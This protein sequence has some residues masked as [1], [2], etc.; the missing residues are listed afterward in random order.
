MLAI[1]PILL[2]DPQTK[3]IQKWLGTEGA[4]EFVEWLINRDAIASAEAANL[5][6]ESLNDPT[7]EADA[8]AKA[9][10]ADDF[11]RLVNLINEARKPD[12]KFERCE[13]APATTHNS[14]IT[15]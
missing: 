3:R 14:T 9:M 5:L 11:R 7:K 6:I 1:N 12:A 2:P 13:I 8:K 10:Q 15:E 4:K